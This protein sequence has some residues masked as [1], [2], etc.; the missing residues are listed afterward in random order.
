MSGAAKSV[1]VFGVYML[2]MGVLLLAF[3]NVLLGLVGYP[4]TEEV[5]LRVLGVVTVILGYYYSVAARNELTS[6][7]RASVF[8][9]PLLV[10]FFIAF[11][12]LGIAE[13]ILVLFGVVDLLGAVWTGLELRQQGESG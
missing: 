7:F 13:P 11:V 10:V 12:A 5:W 3:P 1:L 6:F 8:A 4:T 9:R 2:V